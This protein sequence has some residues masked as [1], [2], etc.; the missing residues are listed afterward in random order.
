M[1]LQLYDSHQS[2][3]PVESE[4]FTFKML[5]M[6]NYLTLF[7]MFSHFTYSTDFSSLQK[8]GTFRDLWYKYIF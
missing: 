2:G 5:V 7:E 4:K 1:C 6:E 3:F 8:E